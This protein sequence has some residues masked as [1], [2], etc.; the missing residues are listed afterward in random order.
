M[1][2]FYRFSLFIALVAI[3]V[4]AFLPDYSTLPPLVSV[5]DLLNHGVA[6]TVLT[7]LY[8]FSY[9]HSLQRVFSSLF[10]YAL[11]IECIQAFLPT[12]CASLED[13]VADSVGL[14]VGIVLSNWIK[15]R[16][17]INSHPKD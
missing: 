2:F 11:L 15:R 1:I 14:F 8:R 5:S 10:G 7:L 12:R 16:E 9:T 3:S 6:F 17:S 13:V 4:L